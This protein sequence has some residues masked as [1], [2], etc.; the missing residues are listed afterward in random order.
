ML[1]VLLLSLSRQYTVD[2]QYI[3]SLFIEPEVRHDKT[4]YIL[5]E[6]CKNAKVQVHHERVGGG[7]GLAVVWQT[8]HYMYS[9]QHWFQSFVLYQLKNERWRQSCSSTTKQKERKERI[10][11]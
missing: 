3:P 8:I 11:S 2:G 10:L 1:K 6:K 5:I 7:G 4:S 9:C